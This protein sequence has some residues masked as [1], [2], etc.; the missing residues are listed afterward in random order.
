MGDKL[1]RRGETMFD[2]A[3]ITQTGVAANVLSFFSFAN[4]RQVLFAF[5]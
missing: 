5:V 3:I 1:K 2:W 4:V